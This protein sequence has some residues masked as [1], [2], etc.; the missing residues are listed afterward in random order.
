MN[1]NELPENFGDS[2]TLLTEA[3][4][5]V[6]NKATAL[7]I[8]GLI[9]P[10]YEQ[11]VN[12]GLDGDEAIAYLSVEL[13]R[14]QRSLNEDLRR[15]SM[16]ADVI[17]ALVNT[18]HDRARFMLNLARAGDADVQRRVA[19][20]IEQV[21]AITIEEALDRVRDPYVGVVPGKEE[22][23]EDPEPAQQPA[24]DGP[25]LS[26]ADLGDFDEAIEKLQLRDAPRSLKVFDLR[27]AMD[28][29]ATTMGQLARRL[30]ATGT[31]ARVFCESEDCLADE[32]EGMRCE[33]EEMKGRLESD[34]MPEVY[35]RSC[36]AAGCVKCDGLG[37]LSRGERDELET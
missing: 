27:T 3:K 20:L 9:R 28:E 26:D 11:H 17:R 8:A 2:V 37:W 21:E 33:L 7:T 23:P 1:T 18:R 15:A 6:A 14:S 5:A 4:T 12:E 36:D 25:C 32:L 35:C 24:E 19:E 16:P 22:Q 10:L 30:M 34:L 29:I 13:G 31:R